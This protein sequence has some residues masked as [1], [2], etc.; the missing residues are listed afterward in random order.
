MRL[1]TSVLPRG[2]RVLPAGCWFTLVVVGCLAGLEVAGRSTTSDVHDGVAALALLGVGAAVVLRHRRE[3][4]PWVQQTL[5]GWGPRASRRRR[6]SGTITESTFAAL[7]RSR[8]ARRRPCGSWSRSW[9]AGES[10]RAELGGVPDGLASG[11][12]L[13]VVHA[14]P[15]RPHDALGGAPGGHFCRGVRPGG[16]PRQVA[17]AVAGR[18]RSPGGGTRGRGRLRGAGLGRRLGWSRRRRYW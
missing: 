7:L 16:V 13:L 11:R 14:L 10:W 15:R 4:L 2:S 18:H 6:G 3:P 1:L 17:Q 5:A 9:S 12:L 8:V